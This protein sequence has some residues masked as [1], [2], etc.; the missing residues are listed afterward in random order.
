MEHLQHAHS[1]QLLLQHWRD[2]AADMASPRP[3][4]I[5]NP[6]ALHISTAPHRNTDI[7]ACTFFTSIARIAWLIPPSPRMFNIV[8]CHVLDHD[9]HGLHASGCHYSGMRPSS[10]VLLGF[11]CGVEVHQAAPVALSQA[12]RRGLSCARSSDAAT[13]TWQYLARGQRAGWAATHVVHGHGC[14]K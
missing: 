6:S 4:A 13:C 11:K 9:P 8:Y 7:V 10:T 2:A 1:V 5:Q 3:P 12:R 14:T